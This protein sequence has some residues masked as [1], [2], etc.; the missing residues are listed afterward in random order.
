MNK[1]FSE[2]EAMLQE[3]CQRIFDKKAFNILTL[4]VRGVCTLTDYFIIA[5]GTVDRHVQ[6]LSKEVIAYFREHGRRPIHTEGERDGDWVVLDYGEVVIHFFIPDMREK[7][8]LEQV[9]KE[10][11]VVDLPL[12]HHAPQA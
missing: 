7:Y 4:D 6:A 8:Q 10:G 12:H 2:E 5:E 1:N 11:K 9:W 3:I